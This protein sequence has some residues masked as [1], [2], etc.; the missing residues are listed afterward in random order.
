[1]KKIFFLILLIPLFSLAQ[2]VGADFIVLNEGKESDYHQLEKIWKAYHQ[3]SVDSGEKIGWSVW[4]RTPR[5]NDNEN[6]AHYVVFNQ[7]S[8]KEQMEN[9]M[10]NWSMNKAISIMKTGM[11]GKM[12]SKTVDR[13]VKNGGKLKKEVRQYTIQ[14]ID[15]TPLAGGNLKKGDKMYF[16]TMSQKLD[17]YEKYESEVWKPVFEREILRNNHRWWAVTKIVD[18]NDLAYQNATHFVWNIP[19]KDPK[20]F[21]EEEDYKSNKLQS[22]MD[23]F[24]QMSPASE[25]TLV[26]LTE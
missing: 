19:I 13:I 2:Y 20:P 21:I 4:K 3:K 26:Y 14:L 17:D 23:E 10:K 18:R 24:R 11:K 1:M 8:S 16:G 15:A 6:A 25:L 12:S 22:M 5:E 7:F 9:F